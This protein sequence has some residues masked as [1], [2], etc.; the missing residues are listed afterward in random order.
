MMKKL[1]NVRGQTRKPQDESAGGAPGGRLLAVLYPA[2]TAKPTPRRITRRRS[3]ELLKLALGFCSSGS[4][5][6]SAMAGNQKLETK[7]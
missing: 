3:R 2:K 1:T 7:N 4:F 6:S 5:A